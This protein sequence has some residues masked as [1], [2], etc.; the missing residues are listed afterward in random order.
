M[1]VCVMKCTNTY[2]Q[3]L[4]DELVENQVLSQLSGGELITL[5]RLSDATLHGKPCLDLGKPCKQLMK[6]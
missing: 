4:Y 5:T 3:L 2:R 6:N 1:C